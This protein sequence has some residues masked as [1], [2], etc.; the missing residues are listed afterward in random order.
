[1]CLRAC[2]RLCARFC[3]RACAWLRTFP[4]APPP[5]TPPPPNSQTQ[6]HPNHPHP[7]PP[8]NPQVLEEE[9]YLRRKDYYN[10]T[11]QR[12]YYFMNVGNGEVIDA[13]RKVGR[14]RRACL[15]VWAGAVEGA[16]AGKIAAVRWAA[17]AAGGRVGRVA[18]PWDG[19]A[20]RRPLPFPLPI[21]QPLPHPP[22]PPPSPPRAAPAPHRA[23]QG[24]PA[25]FI[26][27]SCDPNCETQKWLARG[28]LAI[29]L[30]ALTD[31]EAGQELT[32]DYNFERYGDKPMRC[33]CAA[34]RCRKFIGGT[35]ESTADV[36]A[37]LTPGAAAP[38]GAEGARGLRAR[39]GAR[40]RRRGREP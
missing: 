9:E 29:G 22:T 1:M 38:R 3:V 5:S 21:L 24:N 32:F 40:R 33:Y 25:R 11:G 19:G 7:P 35:A 17:R 8:P 26:N 6:K 4:P 28:E 16:R 20:A 12:H 2:A 23:R 34:A 13:C 18:A 36:Q 10:G 30:F 37:R 14:G 15:G 39:A 27:H 31:I